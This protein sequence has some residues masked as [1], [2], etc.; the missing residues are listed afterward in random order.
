MWGMDW[1]GPAQDRDRC[2]ALMNAVIY[3]RVSFMWELRTDCC[4]IG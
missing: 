1:I 4:A 3:L 2:R